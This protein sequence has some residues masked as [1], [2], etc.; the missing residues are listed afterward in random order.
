MNFPVLSV[1]KQMAQ[2]CKVVRWCGES[3]YLTGK[4]SL[5]ETG[6]KFFTHAMPAIDALLCILVV[7][8]SNDF[9]FSLSCTIYPENHFVIRSNPFWPIDRSIY[10]N[11]KTNGTHV[12]S[13]P[14]QKQ[15]SLVTNCSP[16]SVICC[17]CANL[18]AIRIMFFSYT[19]Q[20]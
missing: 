17:K 4:I 2:F 10:V 15:Y 1:A 11:R 12:V 7:K 8:S 18:Q 16:V 3:C 9:D 5:L 13:K 20:K 6:R 14:S 19:S